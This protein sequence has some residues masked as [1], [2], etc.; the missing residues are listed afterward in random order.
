MLLCFLFKSEPHLPLLLEKEEAR[1]VELAAKQKCSLRYRL[2]LTIS[3][4]NRSLTQSNV[5][6]FNNELAI[7]HLY[8]YD[9]VQLRQHISVSVRVWF[10]G[11]RT[12]MVSKIIDQTGTNPILNWV[13]DN[14]FFGCCRTA[15][16]TVTACLLSL[17]TCAVQGFLRATVKRHQSTLAAQLSCFKG[18]W[19]L[20]WKLRE[21]MQRET[22]VR[23]SSWK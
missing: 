10:T 11:N 3:S 5:H 8:F 7:K 15:V 18:T 12:W 9:R 6:L 19:D 20:A 2:C 1:Q 21:E 22:C 23:E 4:R 16:T 14:F 13:A 17:H